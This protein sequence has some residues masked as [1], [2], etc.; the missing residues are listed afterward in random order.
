MCN[1]TRN[2]CFLMLGV[3]I[4][5]QSVV[6]GLILSIVAFQFVV[7]GIFGFCPYVLRTLRLIDEKFS[8]PFLLAGVVCDEL[9]AHMLVGSAVILDVCKILQFLTIR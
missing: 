1:S 5:N 4:C 8:W 7:C 9:V 6:F 2:L 3:L